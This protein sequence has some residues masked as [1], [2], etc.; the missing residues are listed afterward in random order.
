MKAIAAALKELFGL[1]VDDGSL[2]AG[3]LAL[4]AVLAALVHFGKIGATLAAG[5]L[6]AG[7]VIVL[8]ETV[9]RSA[10]GRRD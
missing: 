4:V 1:F 6:V 9:R 2:A 7:L 10:R 5:L 3:I 8:A